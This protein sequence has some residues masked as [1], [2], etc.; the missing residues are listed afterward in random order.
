MPII[1]VLMCAVP[2][3][4]PSSIGHPPDGEANDDE[5]AD[6]SNRLASEIIPDFVAQL[7][8]LEILP[9]TSTELASAMHAAGMCAIAVGVAVVIPR[10]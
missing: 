5:V 3:G 8:A 7:D 6:V 1:C 2:A 9:C 10:P 4:W